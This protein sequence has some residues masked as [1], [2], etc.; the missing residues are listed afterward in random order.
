MEFVAAP[1]TGLKVSYQTGNVDYWLKGCPQT[2]QMWTPEYPK[3]Q[4]WVP[5]YSL[6]TS[7]TSRIWYHPMF[8]YLQTT[9][10]FLRQ[11]NQST[12]Q[13]NCSRTLVLLRK[14]KRTV[15]GHFTLKCVPP[16]TFIKKRHPI[17]A[18]YQLH[19]HTVEDVPSDKYRNHNQQRPVMARAHQVNSCQGNE[20]SWI[21]KKEPSKL[22]TGY[23][24]W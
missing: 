14:G 17:K 6:P 1:Y 20:I 9:V 23:Q 15:S 13:P 8:N 3:T 24:L 7:M 16:S 4:Y 11:S 10:S 19:S 22:P 5:Y 18:P 21:L 12:T 2:L